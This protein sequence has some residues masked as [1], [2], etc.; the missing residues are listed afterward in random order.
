MS[1]R[2]KGNVNNLLWGTALILL[3]LTA[4]GVNLGY[5]ESDVW[6]D[7]LEL[8]PV[9]LIIL[10]FNII[11][12]QT[13]FEGLA[14]LT[15]VLLIL[16]FAY[17]IYSSMGDMPSPPYRGIIRSEDRW[18]RGEQ[19]QQIYSYETEIG[20]A[21]ELILVLDV[22]GVHLEVD[23]DEESSSVRVEVKSAR[24]K[25]EITFEKE[26]G[27]LRVVG[28]SS[29]FRLNFKR[30]KEEWMIKLP[31]QVKT[32][33]EIN[34]AVDSLKANLREINLTKL[35][36]DGAVSTM[37]FWLPKPSKTNSEVV[38]AAAVTDL[39]IYVPSDAPLQVVT[40]AT[41][42]TFDISQVEL[43]KSNGVWRT[44]NFDENTPHIN[45]SLESALSTVN[46][47]SSD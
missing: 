42:S 29:T 8:W 7:L 13:I 2:I 38:I 24:W 46:I 5:I 36:V 37:D 40:Q 47:R 28:N 41:I 39:N 45:I 6:G 44:I 11:I 34:G 1:D 19:D 35:N 4:L 12:K 18:H 33:I 27:A 10:G 23:S 20:E 16:T 3:G 25:P 30:I 17:A 26:D 31:S 14:Y 43:T 15:P 21:Q 32:I 22:A 9:L